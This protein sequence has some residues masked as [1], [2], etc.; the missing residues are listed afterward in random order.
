VITTKGEG[1]DMGEHR[2]PGEAG[3]S[4]DRKPTQVGQYPSPHGG[5][6]LD[7]LRASG[8]AVLSGRL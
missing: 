4:S 3:T 2:K 7:Y 1:T 5:G 6:A 8:P